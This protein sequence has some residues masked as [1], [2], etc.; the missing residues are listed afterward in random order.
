MN[1]WKQNSDPFFSL[2][3]QFLEVIC[4]SVILGDPLAV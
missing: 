1:P 4:G 2:K 3:S